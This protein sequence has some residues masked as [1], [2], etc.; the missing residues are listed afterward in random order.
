MADTVRKVDY[1]SIKVPNTPAKAFGV[2]STL[3][4]SGIDLL[5]CIGVPKG[6]RAQIDVV[7]TDSRRFK[8]AVKKAGLS[9]TPEKSGFIIQ[10]RDR[11]GALSE[12]LKKLGDKE[13]NVTGIDSMSAGESRWGAI[14]WVEDAAVVKAARVLGARSPRKSS[15]ASVRRVSAKGRKKR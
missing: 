9:F 14:I 4:S 10:G 7:P 1:F 5:A 8:T 2:L 12:H 11:P 6:R 15:A 13:I 3:V